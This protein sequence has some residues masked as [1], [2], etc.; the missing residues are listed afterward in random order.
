MNH[1]QATIYATRVKNM[2]NDNKNNGLD[3]NAIRRAQKAKQKGRKGGGQD[4]SSGFSLSEIVAE[5]KQQERREAQAARLMEQVVTET[6]NINQ[7]NRMI[8]LYTSQ[9]EPQSPLPTVQVTPAVLRNVFDRLNG[10]PAYIV[11]RNRA[12]T[13]VMFFKRREAKAVA[14]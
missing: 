10:D 11:L 6:I 14:A 13:E 2:A 7:H 5:R 1:H 3:Q 12:R 4:H 8:L 9:Q